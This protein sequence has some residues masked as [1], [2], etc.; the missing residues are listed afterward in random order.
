MK[1]RTFTT[2]CPKYTYPDSDAERFVPI[3][4]NQSGSCEFESVGYGPREPIDPTHSKT[5]SWRDEAGGEDSESAL[6]M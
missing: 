3:L 4:N 1:A 2:Y 5:K 6:N